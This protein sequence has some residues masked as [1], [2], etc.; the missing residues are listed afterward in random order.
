MDV[1]TTLSELGSIIYNCAQKSERLNNK[2]NINFFDE[3]K[4]MKNYLKDLLEAVKNY[5]SSE[6]NPELLLRFKEKSREYKRLINR[7]KHQNLR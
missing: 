6:E 7:K 2:I 3:C 4:I 5:S 1:D